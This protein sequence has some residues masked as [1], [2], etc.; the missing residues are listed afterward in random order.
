MT[1]M[2]FEAKFSVLAMRQYGFLSEHTPDNI[3]VCS[4]ESASYFIIDLTVQI[5]CIKE[6]RRMAYGLVYQQDGK[7]H[8]LRLGIT[9]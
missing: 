2:S 9:A 4:T 1:L 5:M 6:Q 8:S 7:L 3:E